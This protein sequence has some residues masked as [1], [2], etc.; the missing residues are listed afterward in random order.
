MSKQE[1]KHLYKTKKITAKEYFLQLG[2]IIQSEAPV[3]I[4]EKSVD[5]L[6]IFDGKLPLF[7]KK[8]GD[9]TQ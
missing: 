7:S 5:I 1:L 6:E 3:S 2:K 9:F 4:P 8:V